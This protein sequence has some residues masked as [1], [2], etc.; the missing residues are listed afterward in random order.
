MLLDV[1][2]A[3]IYT[4]PPIKE[5]CECVVMKVCGRLVDWLVELDSAAYK[6]YIVIEN[7]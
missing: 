1:P 6:N 5:I 2:N 3:F 7:G 4:Y